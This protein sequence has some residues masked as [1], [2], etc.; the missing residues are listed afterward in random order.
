MSLLFNARRAKCVKLF[1]PVLKHI[2]TNNNQRAIALPNLKRCLIISMGYV[3]SNRKNSAKSIIFGFSLLGLVG[4]KAIDANRQLFDYT[5]EKGILYLQNDDYNAFEQTLHEALEIAN[6]LNNVNGI[7]H[8]YDVLANGAFMNKEYEKAKD[9]FTKVVI[10]LIDQGY[11]K[12]DLNILHFNLQITKIYEIQ[13]KYKNSEDGY[14]Y[15]LQHLEKKL[16]IHPENKNILDLYANTLNVYGRFLKKQKE[17]KLAKV[18]F[19]KAYIISVK[20]NGKISENNVILLNVLGTLYFAEGNLNKAIL[21]FTKA[22]DIGQ[23]LPKMQS[24]AVVHINIAHTYLRLGM[25][26]KAEENCEKAL[27]NAKIHSYFRAKK[28]AEICL[29]KINNAMKKRQIGQVRK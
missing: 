16:K 21:Y 9:L 13:E 15:C 28:E 10:R 7:T 17:I 3:W 4:L 27:K 8:V 22:I 20:L 12:D 29:A 19:K 6:D 25:L 2:S 23:H 1:F 11:P 14:I 18:S 24:F 5:I 26:E